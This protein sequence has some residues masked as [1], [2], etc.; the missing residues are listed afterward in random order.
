MLTLSWAHPSCV[1]KGT[2]VWLN[3]SESCMH[4]TEP[5]VFANR[6]RFLHV[7]MAGTAGAVRGTQ[8]EALTW[9]FVGQ[10]AAYGRAYLRIHHIRS[11]MNFPVPKDRH[12]VLEIRARTFSLL[13]P[14]SA[15]RDRGQGWPPELML[16]ILS[17][18]VIP[19][20]FLVVLLMILNL[21]YPAFLFCFVFFSWF[22][23]CC[24][25]EQQSASE[26]MLQNLWQVISDL[27][28]NSMFSFLCF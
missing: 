10:M 4:S 24:N 7:S 14:A 28:R 17:H 12:L 13:L 18:S 15:G 26:K 6:P 9:L 19:C 2:L 8:V 1:S 27:C 21:I 11:V 5:G 20:F 3:S 25:P 22:G 23:F 16:I